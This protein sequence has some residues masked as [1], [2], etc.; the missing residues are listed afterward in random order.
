MCVKFFETIK[1][2]FKKMFSSCLA[3]YK[4]F[5]NDFSSVLNS[6]YGKLLM[7]CLTYFPLLEKVLK[8]NFGKIIMSPCLESRPPPVDDSVDDLLGGGQVGAPV[9]LETV[10]N[11]EKNQY[12]I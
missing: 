5:K 12:F 10:V 2:I 3:S 6:I 7:P 8:H 1:V 9:K 4:T 11:L